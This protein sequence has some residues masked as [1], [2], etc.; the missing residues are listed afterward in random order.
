V[1]C[2]VHGAWCMVHGAWCMV[3]GACCMVPTA[4]HRVNHVIPHRPVLRCVL[5]LPNPSRAA[6]GRAT[7]AAH[8]VLQM[9]RHVTTRCLLDKAGLDAGE[10][11]SRDAGEP[12]HIAT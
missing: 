9:L 5:S 2:T 8:A 4:T 6:A 10:A 1:R 7:A 3:H 11:G 12:R